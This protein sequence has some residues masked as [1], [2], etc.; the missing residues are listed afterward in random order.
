MLLNSNFTNG[1]T[2]KNTKIAVKFLSFVKFTLHLNKHFLIA[3][4]RRI[5]QFDQLFTKPQQPPSKSYLGS[6]ALM[7]S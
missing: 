7:I 6:I 3:V 4:T 2:K 1:N 5:K